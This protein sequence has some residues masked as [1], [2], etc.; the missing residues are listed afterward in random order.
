MISRRARYLW[1]VAPCLLGVVALGARAGAADDSLRSALERLQSRYENTRTMR[2]VFRQ[3]VDSPTL[4][5]ALES[6]GRVLFEKPN[7]MRWDYDPPDA[8]VIVGDGTDLWIYQPDLEQAIRAPIDKVF[9]SRTPLTFLAGLGRIERDFDASL[10]REDDEHWD[11]H[12]VPKGDETLGTLG[13]LV[14]KRDASIAE[15]RITDPL[16]TTTSLRF[17]DE[18]RNVQIDPARFRFTPPPGVDVVRP[19]TY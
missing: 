17:S 14:R 19:P 4:Q 9:Q 6:T 18:E 8:Q 16:G 12:L 2:A 1:L 10:A 5:N 13:L 7:L 3:R 15:A 11:L